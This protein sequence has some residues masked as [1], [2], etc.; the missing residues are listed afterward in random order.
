MNVPA[1]REKIKQAVLDV[2]PRA[3]ADRAEQA[4]RRRRVRF[5]AGP[6]DV[7]EMFA[8]LPAVQGVRLQGSLD[9]AAARARTPGDE[10]TADERRIDALVDAVVAAVDAGESPDPAVVAWLPDR[11]GG[12]AG[13]SK[14]EP[15][16]RPRS[17][18]PVEVIVTVPL[19]TLTGESDRPGH[20]SRYGPITA[21][22]ARGMAW[23]VA[24]QGSW[25]CAVVDG[26]HGT[27]LGLGR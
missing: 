17:G 5:S 19:E 11:P 2:A 4:C 6:D 13:P 12:Q 10:R 27:L 7:M 20:L 1:P 21:D 25:R 18:P 14:Q 26:E 23:G 24:D 15:R 16:S 3:A 8:V 22:L 9:V